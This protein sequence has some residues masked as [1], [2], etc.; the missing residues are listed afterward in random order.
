MNLTTTFAA[1]GNSQIVDWDGGV[2]Y[3]AA[4]GDFGGGTVQLEYSYDGGNTFIP[5]EAS[6]WLTANSGK[7]FNLPPCKLRITLSGAA[8]PA[9]TVYVR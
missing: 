1:N 8:N 6:G 2:G 5:T 3:F 7:K 9:I 4:E